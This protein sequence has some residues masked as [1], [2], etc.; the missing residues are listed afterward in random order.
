M[1]SF[2]LK[3]LATS[4]A[5][6]RRRRRCCRCCCRRRRC[7]CSV[8]IAAALVVVVAVVVIVIA[9]FLTRVVSFAAGALPL[10]SKRSDRVLVNE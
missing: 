4:Y 1:L 6:R 10:S 5:R 7:C 3:S 9:V 2:L 8:I